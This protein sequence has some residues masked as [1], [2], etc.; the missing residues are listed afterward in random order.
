MFQS[1]S[2]WVWVGIVL[3]CLVCLAIISR[4]W[5]C[6][7]TRPPRP[8]RPPQYATYRVIEVVNGATLRIAV[9]KRSRRVHTLQL[10]GI[11]APAEGAW[12]FA[13][14]RDHLRQIAGT[15]VRI[16]IPSRIDEEPPKPER[17]VVTIAWGESGACL[18]LEQVR[19]GWA[20]TTSE[21]PAQWVEAERAARSER[22]G[23][24]QEFQDP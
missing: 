21:A 2:L 22:L 10:M 7:E 24:W 19:A 20:K 17:T 4:N 1:F 18:N 12:G 16:Q 23:I 13:E 14:S 3:I 8:P 5:S 15:Q 11:A 9:G 6:R